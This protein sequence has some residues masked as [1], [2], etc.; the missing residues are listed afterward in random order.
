MDAPDWIFARAYY[1]LT[2]IWVK[3]YHFGIKI[4]MK[5]NQ[6]KIL[7]KFLHAEAILLRPF[8][9]SYK[10]TNKNDILSAWRD[11]K[12]KSL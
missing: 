1:I 5:I 2:H 9:Q 7:F 3:F 4:M 10:F 12:N 6:E 8:L 11:F